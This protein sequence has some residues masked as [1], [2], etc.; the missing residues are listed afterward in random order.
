MWVI[1]RGYGS[2]LII[3]RGYSGYIFRGEFLRLF[4][5]IT[6]I[7]LEESSVLLEKELESNLEK[8]QDNE[9]IE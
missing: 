5:N 4:S 3:T 2:S 9:D 7:D 8:I 6:K 1:T